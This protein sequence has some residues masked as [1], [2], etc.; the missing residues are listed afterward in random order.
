MRFAR[1]IFIDILSRIVLSFCG[2]EAGENMSKIKVISHL[3]ALIIG[4]SMSSTIAS[5]MLPINVSIP[6]VSG[7]AGS[8]VVVPV[9]VTDTTGE[10]VRASKTTI[11]YDPDILTATGISTEGTIASGWITAHTLNDGQVVIAM[12]GYT[13]LNGTGTLVKVNFS[14][15]ITANPGEISPLALVDVILYKY[16][17]TE[18]AITTT[19][20]TFTVSEPPAFQILQ[21]YSGLNFFST[22]IV[23]DGSD[24]ASVLKPIE[25]LYSAVWAYY[26]NPGWKRYIYG[27]DDS[28]NDLETIAPG[29]G[30]CIDM[31]EESSLMIAGEQITDADI[32]LIAGWNLV[33]CNFTATKDRDTA[34]DS[35]MSALNSI[36]TYD[37]E[38]KKWLRYTTSGPEL[39]NDLIELKPGSAY[40]I[41]VKTNCLWVTPP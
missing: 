18:P 24:P 37:N 3:L 30:Y 28:A 21:L 14:V 39:L 22:Y 40:W 34:L 2:E 13:P 29:T 33:G 5:A 26:R 1:A 6:D 19:D 7:L 16:D 25:G 27:G 11:I 10:G 15:S 8:E 32:P 9:N 23:T 38:N 35:I 36:Y 12:A 17:G 4:L 31:A 41:N 20:G